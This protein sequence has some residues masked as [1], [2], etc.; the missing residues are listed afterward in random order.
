MINLS[1]GLETLFAG[2][3]SSSFNSSDQE[4]KGRSPIQWTDRRLVIGLWDLKI[5]YHLL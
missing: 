5:E 4:H 1:V 2:F 3:Q